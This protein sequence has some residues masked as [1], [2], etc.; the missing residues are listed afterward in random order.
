MKRELGDGYQFCRFLPEKRIQKERR[1]FP[2]PQTVASL[3]VGC[4]RIESRLYPEKGS[5]T[6]VWH[7]FVKDDPDS[8]DWIFYGSPEGP[9]S[10]REREM[11]RVLDRIVQRDH[12][13]YTECCFERLEGCAVGAGRREKK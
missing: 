10:G 5:L 2:G 6:P 1:P 9:A 4:V 3:T 13:S 12:L 8:P 11:F 7:V